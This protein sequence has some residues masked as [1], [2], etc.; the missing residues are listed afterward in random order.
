MVVNIR[1]G[2]QRLSPMVQAVLRTIEIPNLLLYKAVDAPGMQVVVAIFLPVVAQRLLPMVQ[3]VLMDK[4]VDAP[5]MQVVVALFLPVV[6]QRIPMVC[7]VLMDKVVDA[8]V[9]QVVPVVTQRLIPVVQPVQQVIVITQ[10]LFVPG[11][12]VDA[13]RASPTGAGCG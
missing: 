8:P 13:G 12:Y 1:V 3:T 5:A 11:V 6:A 10:L 2:V 7:T 9:V 4:V